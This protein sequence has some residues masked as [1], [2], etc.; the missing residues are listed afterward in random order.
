LTQGED[1]SLRQREITQL[2]SRIALLEEQAKR[3]RGQNQQR[4]QSMLSSLKKSQ[5]VLDGMRQGNLQLRAVRCLGFRALLCL[6][7]ML[8][9]TR[10]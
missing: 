2:Q 7:E 5:G 3:Q 4:L 9:Y 6:T 1:I 10:V 8:F